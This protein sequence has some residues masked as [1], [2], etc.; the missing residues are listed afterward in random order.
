MSNL[1]GVEKIVD[2]L[3]LRSGDILKR[4]K[5]LYLSCASDVW[6]D[7]N[8]SV[9]K[10][11]KRI[12]V[13]LRS[14]FVINKRTNSID[15]PCDYLRICSVNAIDKHGVFYPI[16][17]ND[18]ITDELIDIS[19]SGN[20]EN[21][22]NHYLCNTIKGYES[23][24]STKTDFL[25]NGETI[26][27]DCLDKKGVLGDYF[28]TETQFPL[29]VFVSG[30]W[31]DT[32]LRTEQ[33]K[34]CKLEMDDK[35]CIKD[36]PSN[37]DSLCTDCGINSDSVIPYGGNADSPPLNTNPS[38]WI[39]YCN[40]KADIFSAQCGGYP[41]HLTCE[42]NRIYNISELNNRIIFPHNF[43]F[44]KVMI[45]YYSNVELSNIQVPYMA[46]ECFMT[47][48]QY[49]SATNNDMKQQLANVYGVK[50]SKQKKGLLLDLNK[51]R[52]SE[53][54]MILTPPIYIPSFIER[55]FGWYGGGNY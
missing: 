29:R 10:M 34:M 39:Y 27:F 50:Y 38:Q 2:D 21:G 47:G 12:A 7:L 16:Y 49:F 31:V 28:Y 3:C 33:T 52:I 51:Y 46:K 41:H 40:T 5:G 53:L 19:G 8:E 1:I 4:N 9:L 48:I 36:T 43:G 11:A 22:C 55:N 23:V 30:V 15:M 37:F 17:R 45:R 13:P 14:V 35:G 25:P 20:C 44:D 42:S 24:R 26:S 18:K 32:I 54:Q 6:N